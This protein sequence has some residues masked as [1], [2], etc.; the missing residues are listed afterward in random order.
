MVNNKC[1]AS[2]VVR[3][4]SY[5]NSN[6]YDTYSLDNQGQVLL[7]LKE[8]N[9]FEFIWGSVSTQDDDNTQLLIKA[10]YLI[11]L[12]PAGPY[13]NNIKS[14]CYSHGIESYERQDRAV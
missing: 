1:T 2:Y 10:N 12:I 3:Y 13:S 7:K 9:T 5:I 14:I 6:E 11:K 4:N 8:D